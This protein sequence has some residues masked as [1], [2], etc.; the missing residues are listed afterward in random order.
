ML[1]Y[2]TLRKW[3]KNQNGNAVV[4]FALILPVLLI[5]GLGLVDAGRAIG[6]NARLGTGVESGL[7]YALADAYAD[8][9]ISG[10][11]IDG[12]RYVEG[13]ASVDVSRFCECPDGSAVDCSGTCAQGYKRIYVQIAMA[14]TQDTLFSYPVLGS[15]ITVNRTGALQIP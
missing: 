2:M 7:R 5:M 4:E 6:A 14:H 9:E 15:S 13:E 1:G 11:A 8:A 10:A 3:R 12:S